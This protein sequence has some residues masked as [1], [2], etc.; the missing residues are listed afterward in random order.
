[1]GC[2]TVMIFSAA[3]G[4]LG[5]FLHVLRDLGHEND[6]TFRCRV[7]ETSENPCPLSGCLA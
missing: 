3:Y 5:W 2:F 4:R 6:I 7:S 1:M